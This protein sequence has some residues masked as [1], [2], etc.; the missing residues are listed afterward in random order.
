MFVFQI[1]KKPYWFKYEEYHSNINITPYMIQKYYF[2][3]YY[4]N[5]K[6]G[7]WII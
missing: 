7:G 6:K 3:T 5:T 2:Y 4:S 1:E